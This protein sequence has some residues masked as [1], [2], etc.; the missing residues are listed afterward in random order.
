MELFK[1]HGVR[2]YQSGKLDGKTSDYLIKNL[3]MTGAAHSSLRSR[4]SASSRRNRSGTL[5]LLL[6]N[7]AAL[8]ELIADDWKLRV[9]K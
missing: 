7:I 3:F 2:A 1:G 8:I 9:P 4:R 5:C 6:I